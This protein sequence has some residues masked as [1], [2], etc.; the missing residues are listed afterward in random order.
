MRDGINPA[1]GFNDRFAPDL[2]RLKDALRREGTAVASISHM[3]QTLLRTLKVLNDSGICAAA[4]MLS[5]G[6][7]EVWLGDAEWGIRSSALFSGAEL[8]AAARWLSESAV[9]LYP[10]SSYARTA[11]L[12]SCWVERA[13]QQY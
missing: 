12:I 5:D 4:R 6:R 7:V 9:R 10:Q 1:L 13:A 2:H 8:D 3:E 11:Q